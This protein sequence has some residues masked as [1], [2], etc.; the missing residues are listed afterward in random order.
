MRRQAF[1]ARQAPT[2]NS[3][4]DDGGRQR[5]DDG[6]ASVEHV[7]VHHDGD[8]RRTRQAVHTGSG[9]RR[10]GVSVEAVGASYSAPRATGHKDTPGRPRQRTG[11]P[12]AA[13]CLAAGVRAVPRQGP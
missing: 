2:K 12:R 9:K 11:G 1:I 10:A 3:I 5:A 8:G 6:D 4:Y 7:T 13:I